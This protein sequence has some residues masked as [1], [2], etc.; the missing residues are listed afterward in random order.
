MFSPSNENRRETIMIKKTL[1][2]AAVAAL[3]LAAFDASAFAKGGGGGGHGGG[4]HHHFRGGVVFV[5][6]TPDY[7]CGYYTRSGHWVPRLC[8]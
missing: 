2:G 1:L 6:V 5:P 7:S 4:G 8:N 3:S